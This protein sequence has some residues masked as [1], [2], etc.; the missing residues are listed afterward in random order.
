MA[1]PKRKT[2][3]SRRGQ[4]RAHDFLKKANIAF[5]KT[6]GEA[7]LSHHISLSDGYYN[8]KKVYEPKSKLVAPETTAESEAQ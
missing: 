2:S 1:V 6:T 3:P 4:R 8:G 7:K 5:D